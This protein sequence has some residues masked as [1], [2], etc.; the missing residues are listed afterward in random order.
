MTIQG[1]H[2]EGLVDTGADISIIALDQWPK[3]WPKQRASMGLIGI[4]TASEVYQS[5]TILH[6]LGPDG[7]EG[8]IQPTITSIPINLWGKDCY[9][10]G[11]QK[12][13]FPLR[14]TVQRVKA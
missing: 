1:K 6:C 7:Q 12:S 5:V 14:F 8:T 10:S 4:G 3:T 9:N 13:P 2:F 11:V